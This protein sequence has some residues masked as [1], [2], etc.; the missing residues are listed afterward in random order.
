MAQMQLGGITLLIAC[1]CVLIAKF[2][3]VD[4]GMRSHTRK[5]PPSLLNS[6]LT[7][8]VV[9]RA[10]IIFIIQQVHFG[11]SK[12]YS[13]SIHLQLKQQIGPLFLPH[14]YP[15]SPALP[16]ILHSLFRLRML[17]FSYETGSAYSLRCRNQS[18][19]EMLFFFCL[20]FIRVFL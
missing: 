16:R 20:F 12:I 19:V 13:G 17:Q 15:M 14:I 6:T 10:L 4:I 2:S 7:M 8:K 11:K 3:S 5:L 9:K 1:L 18:L